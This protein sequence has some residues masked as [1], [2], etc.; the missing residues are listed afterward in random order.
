MKEELSN[1]VDSNAAAIK[2][3]A[4]AERKGTKRK[5]RSRGS[6]RSG[7]RRLK[8]ALLPDASTLLQDASLR[9]AASKSDLLL[10][11]SPELGLVDASGNPIEMKEPSF[12]GDTRKEIVTLT[13]PRE[14]FE[15]LSSKMREILALTVLTQERIAKDQEEINLLKTETRE[16]LRRLRAA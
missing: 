10:E 15:Q 6:D 14:Q 11:T 12:A 13:I 7:V 3:I 9:R 5:E 2:S 16:T 4:K 1:K 8:Q